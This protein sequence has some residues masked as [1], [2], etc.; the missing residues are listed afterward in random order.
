[1]PFSTNDLISL[2]N[3]I[4]TRLQGQS[5]FSGVTVL[6]ATTG[7]VASRVLQLQKK[8]GIVVTVPEPRLAPGANACEW[9][10]EF[11]VFIDECPALNRR[12]GSGR[13]REDL[14]IDT[15]NALFDPAHQFTPLALASE[16]IFDGM[17]RGETDAKLGSAVIHCT[18]TAI[19]GHVIFQLSRTH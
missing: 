3:A 4:V 9:L 16:A 15:I 11:E 1:M 12:T 18:H 2:R 5:G 8:S 17:D 10:A 6:G 14:E 7:D 13:R 19:G